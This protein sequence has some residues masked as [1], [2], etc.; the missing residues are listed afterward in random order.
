MPDESQTIVL[1]GA[2]AL[3]D[4]TYVVDPPDLMQPVLGPVRHYW[5]EKRSGPELPRRSDIDPV[6]LKAYLSHLFLI[7]VLPDAEFRFRLVG[8]E[9]T[10][11]YGRNSTGRTVREVYAEL[12]LI[13]DWLTDMMSAV[14]RLGRPVL[15][16]GPLTAI[17]KEHVFSESLF[18]PLANEAGSITKIFGATC[19]RARGRS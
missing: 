7:D 3:K 16:S 8:G 12:P 17:G 15:A 5:E 6:E 4:L 11:R 18:L 13:A 19:Y 9:I 1:D 10:D 2:K 14:T